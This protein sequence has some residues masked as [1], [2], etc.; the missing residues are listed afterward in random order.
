MK[1]H[2]KQQFYRKYKRQEFLDSGLTDSIN[3]A[4]ENISTAM[5]HL[6]KLADK[7]QHAMR[8]PDFSPYDNAVLPY[9]IAVS[10]ARPISVKI[11]IRETPPPIWRANPFVRDK[12][13][14][15][16][17]EVW[18]TTFQEA[19][20]KAVEKLKEIYGNTFGPLKKA[21]LITRICYPNSVERDL[22]NYMIKFANNAFRGLLIYDD[23]YFYEPYIICHSVTNQKKPHM[24]I[25]VKELTPEAEDFFQQFCGYQWDTDLTNDETEWY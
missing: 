23:S 22:D 9:E 17:R 11:T 20:E 8:D 4:L 3:S 5:A 7:Y 2:A 25:I 15:A 16:L 21:A 1:K 6:Y 12:I 18:Q 14:R 10:P 13:H 19:A 24:D